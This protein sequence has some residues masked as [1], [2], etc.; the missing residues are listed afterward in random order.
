[1]RHN[2]SVSLDLRHWVIARGTP[3]L[4][5]CFPGNNFLEDLSN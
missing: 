4:S 5:F 1:M 2:A 3:S